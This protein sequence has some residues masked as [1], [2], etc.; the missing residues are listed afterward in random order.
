M[1]KF[2]I[3]ALGVASLAGVL[4]ETASA[5]PIEVSNENLPI[6]VKVRGE[7]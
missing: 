3:V 1:H 6:I 2:L 7:V 4:T 5:T